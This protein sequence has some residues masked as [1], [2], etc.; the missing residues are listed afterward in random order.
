MKLLCEAEP[1][2]FKVLTCFQK[3][4]VTSAIVYNLDKPFFFF[5]FARVVY[6]VTGNVQDLKQVAMITCEL[7]SGHFKIIVLNSLWAAHVLTAHAWDQLL[8]PA[9][10]LVIPLSKSCTGLGLGVRISWVL[11]LSLPAS[12][13]S[14]FLTGKFSFS[15]LGLS[16]PNCKFR[17]CTGS[18]S[19]FQSWFEKSSSTR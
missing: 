8:P 19:K 1:T 14:Q 9:R 4:A 11:V 10:A 7:I 6:F 15:S 3:L 17:G 18:P 16:F 5:F 2:C 12:G 13:N